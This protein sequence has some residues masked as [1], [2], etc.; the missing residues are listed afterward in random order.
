MECHLGSAGEGEEVR[1]QLPSETRRRDNLDECCL[2]Q[3][4]GAYAGKRDSGALVE[5]AG[6]LTCGYSGFVGPLKQP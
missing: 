4:E 3:M 6:S 2:F 1:I 5:A